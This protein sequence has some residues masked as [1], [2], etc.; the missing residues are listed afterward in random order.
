MQRRGGALARALLGCVVDDDVHAARLERVEHHL[1][2]RSQIR[3][4]TVLQIVVV[5]RRP[6]HIERF[7]GGGL[8]HVERH[9]THVAIALFCSNGGNCSSRIIG[10]VGCARRCHGIDS[11]LITHRLA[12]DAGEVATAREHVGDLV[13]R[14]DAGKGHQFSRLAIGITGAISLG[15]G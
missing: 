15:T 11:A 2:E 4:L 9:H 5:E 1:V 6:H 10:C 13:A 14:L 12:E 3:A 8:D 7:G